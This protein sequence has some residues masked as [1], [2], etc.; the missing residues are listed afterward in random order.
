MKIVNTELLDIGEKRDL[1][2][3]RYFP[4]KEREAKIVEYENNG[5]AQ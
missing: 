2:G 5:L 3:K 4:K 1:K